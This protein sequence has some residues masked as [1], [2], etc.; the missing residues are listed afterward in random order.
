[1]NIHKSTAISE[2]I[3]TALLMA[4]ATI[5]SIA[6]NKFSIKKKQG[7]SANSPNNQIKKN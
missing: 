3:N 4:Q 2:A 1:M 5:R 6:I 7:Q